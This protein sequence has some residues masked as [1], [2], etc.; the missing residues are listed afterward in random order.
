MID[1]NL[2]NNPKIFEFSSD[3]KSI[4]I[5]FIDIVFFLLIFSSLFKSL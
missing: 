1:T 3:I 5:L 2:Y 4:S